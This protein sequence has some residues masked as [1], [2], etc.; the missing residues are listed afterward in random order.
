[1]YKERVTL[2]GEKAM[3]GNRF[4]PELGGNYTLALRNLLEIMRFVFS[5]F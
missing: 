5:H 4:G 1:M 3:L 2:G